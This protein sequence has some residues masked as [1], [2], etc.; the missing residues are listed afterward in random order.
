MNH[1]DLQYKEHSVYSMKNN[2]APIALFVYNRLWHTKQTIESL[3]ANM[4]ANESDLIIYSDGPKN[5]SENL[6]ENQ[7]SEINEVR[8]YIKSVKGFRTIKIIERDEN[9]GLARNII[10]GVTETISKNG[11]II[12]LEDDIITSPAFILFMN[13]ALEFYEDKRKVWHISGWNYPIKKEDLGEVFFWKMMNCWGWA[14]WSD[15]WDYFIRDTDYFLNAFKSRKTKR[16][17]N[18]DNSI[19][20]YSHLE[21]N[22]IG[23]LNTWAIYWYSVIFENDGLA[24]NPTQ[25]YTFNIGFDGSG[26]NC[27]ESDFLQHLDYNALNNPKLS[28][29]ISPSLIARKRII[30][31][32]RKNN[33]YLTRIK[34]KLTQWKKF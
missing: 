9:Y 28:Y 27:G 10:D 22:K 21:L 19:N 15:R 32:Y 20:F 25:S 1:I 24:L 23:K 16:E 18:L 4:L 12:V 31:F 8:K 33:S 2:L 11:K 3:K 29:N 26:T 13:Q 17:F 14:T 5:N 30:D 34:K 7:I 6:F